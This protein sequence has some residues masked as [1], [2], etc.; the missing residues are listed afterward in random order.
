[1]I[2]SRKLMV[3]EPPEMLLTPRLIDLN[4]HTSAPIQKNALPRTVINNTYLLDL[5]GIE[6]ERHSAQV[7]TETLLLPR[8]RDGHDI[9]VDTP[10]EQDLTRVDPVFPRQTSEDVVDGA[11]TAFRDGG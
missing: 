7:V 1:M 2:F 5:L 10:S 6:L 3:P 9:L 8:S 4:K 11:G